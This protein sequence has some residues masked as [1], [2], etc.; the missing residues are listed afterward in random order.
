ML[1]SNNAEPDSEEEPVLKINE[2]CVTLWK[3]GKGYCRE[4]KEEGTFMADHIHHMNKNS[5]LTWKFP[6]RADICKVDAEQVL[7]YEIVGEWDYSSDRNMTFTLKNHEVIQKIFM[8][9]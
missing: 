3:E 8:D 9:I 4:V 6:T 2:I 7:E 1:R 5:N